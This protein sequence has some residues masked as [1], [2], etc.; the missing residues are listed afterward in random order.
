MAD[1]MVDGW[2]AGGSFGGEG[3]DALVSATWSWDSSNA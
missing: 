2:G 3:G 1:A